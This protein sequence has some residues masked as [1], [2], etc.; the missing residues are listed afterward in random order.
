MERGERL[1]SSFFLS[2]RQKLDHTEFFAD[3]RKNLQDFV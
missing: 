2:Y 1:L 3:S